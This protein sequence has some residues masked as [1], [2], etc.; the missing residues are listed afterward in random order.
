MKSVIFKVAGHVKFVHVKISQTSLFNLTK[1]NQPSHLVL[2]SRSD[3][4]GKLLQICLHIFEK[5]LP[6]VE[7]H[8][9]CPGPLF[10][11]PKTIN[12]S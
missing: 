6:H 1:I 10:L 7:A 5:E 3:R 9:G 12:I 8:F 4:Q 11:D 2:P